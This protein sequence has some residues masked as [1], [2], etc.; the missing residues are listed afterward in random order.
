MRIDHNSTNVPNN[1]AEFASHIDLP[2]AGGNTYEFTIQASDGPR[3]YPVTMAEDMSPSVY[4]YVVDKNPSPGEPQYGRGLPA[5]VMTDGDQPTLKIEIENTYVIDEFR[6]FGAGLTRT[7][8]TSEIID[9]DGDG[10]VDD[11]V[12]IIRKFSATDKMPRYSDMLKDIVAHTFNRGVE[13]HETKT[14]YFRPDAPK[15]A[16]TEGSKTP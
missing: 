6:P 11:Q 8:R 3:T 10:E 7:T 12:E 15:V 14:V 9:F 16:A 5:E 1:T 2:D 4:V 13:V